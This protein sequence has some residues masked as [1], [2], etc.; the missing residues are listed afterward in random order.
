MKKQ[1]IVSVLFGC[2]ALFGATAHAQQAVNYPVKPVRIV[3]GYQAGGPTDMVARMV[4]NKLQVSLGQAFVVENRPGAGSNLASEAVAS[5]APDGYT[6]LI[7]A[8]PLTMNS[9][10]YKNLKFNVKKDF[11]PISL[12]SS[13]PGVLAVSAEL[14]VKNVQELIALAKKTPGVLTYGSSGSGG[15]QHMFGERL[16]RLAGIQLIHVPYKGASGALNDL[17]AGHLDMT[18]MTSTGSMPYLQSG[19]VKPLAVAGPTRLSGIPNVPTFAEIGLPDMASDSWNGLLAPA[20]TSPAI[21]KKLHAAVVEAMES[22]DLKGKLE[23]QGA[24]VKGSTPAEF[25]KQID[26]DLKH[27]EEQFKNTKIDRQ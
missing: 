19:K 1:S 5:A 2:S 22:P 13:A 9:F 8:A 21:I 12:L 24:I 4:A 14:P 7:A 15:S 11:E 20:G 17:L 25:R 27:W 16:Q 6:L 26:A 18:F 23:S 3:V 10:V